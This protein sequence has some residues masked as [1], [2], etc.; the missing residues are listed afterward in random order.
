MDGVSFDEASWKSMR[1]EIPKCKTLVSLGFSGIDWWSCHLKKVAEVEFAVDFVQLLKDCPNILF[2]NTMTFFYHDFRGPF[3]DGSELY[4]THF[5]PILEHNR[6]TKHLIALKGKENYQVRGFLVAE[7]VGRQY[8]TKPSS[9]YRILKE[10]VDVLVSYLSSDDRAQQIVREAIDAPTK[11]V[12]N[13][14]SATAE[15]QN[16][17][18]TPAK[19]KR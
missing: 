3:D 1:Q 7:A 15:K 5:A 2:T 6:L 11:V 18:T 19:R 8:A 14:T 12:R 17:R 10:N 13:P 9:C 4:A 16:K